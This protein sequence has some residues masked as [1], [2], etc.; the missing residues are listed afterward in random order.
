[1]RYF[2]I[3]STL[4]FHKGAVWKTVNELRFWNSKVKNNITKCSRVRNFITLFT[5]FHPKHFT[6]RN[7]LQP[8]KNKHRINRRNIEHNILERSEI[9]VLNTLHMQYK[10]IQLTILIT[11]IFKI[12]SNNFFS[13]Y[14][15]NFMFSFW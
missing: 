2:N 9:I 3:F 4:R 7:I 6:K 12:V 10:G 15:L 11:V 14:V 5:Y 1:M 8:I 13:N